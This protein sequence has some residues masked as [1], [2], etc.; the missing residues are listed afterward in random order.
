MASGLAFT[1]GL[2]GRVGAVQSCGLFFINLSLNIVI[3]LF[4]S[5]RKLDSIIQY[6]DV[7]RQRL[8]ECQTILVLICSLRYRA[9][10]TVRT[11]IQKNP[12]AASGDPT[13]APCSQ[14]QVFAGVDDAGRGGQAEFPAQ[15]G[16]PA[17]WTTLGKVQRK[18]EGYVRLIGP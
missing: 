12:A 7:N 5:D 18:S 4:L 3:V 16:T 13:I 8:K 15:D 11:G 2:P 1:G 14:F 6:N 10:R 9:D 17:E